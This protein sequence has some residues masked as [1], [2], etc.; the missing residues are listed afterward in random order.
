MPLRV[1]MKPLLIILTGHAPDAIRARLGDFDH[2]FRLALR[3]SAREIRVVDV[4]AGVPLPDTTDIRGAVISGSAAMVTEKLV[5]SER[6]A[7]WVRDAMDAQLPL[8]GVCYGHQLMAHALGGRVDVLPGGREM[9][10]KDIEVLAPDTDDCLLAGL[11]TRFAAHTTHM[12]SVLEVPAGAQVLARSA[13]DPHQILRYGP[14]AISTQLHPEFSAAA[15]RAYLRLRADHLRS[16]SMDV[17]DLLNTVRATP[18]A[19]R[20]L[21]RFARETTPHAM[22]VVA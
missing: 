12:Q 11:P 15:M 6:L 4:S 17:A 20:L 3:L 9:G 19:R 7:G 2:W 18:Q 1:V 16:E 10:T 21:Q 13:R 14:N 8:F 22:D 5:W